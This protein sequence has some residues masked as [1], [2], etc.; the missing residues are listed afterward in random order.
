MIDDGEWRDSGDEH[1][2]RRVKNTAYRI[3]VNADVVNPPSLSE[4]KNFA[5]DHYALK[6][7]SGYIARGANPRNN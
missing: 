7:L 2:P 1:K 5:L 3:R 4:L 6:L